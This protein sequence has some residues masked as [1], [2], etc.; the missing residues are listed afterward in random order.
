MGAGFLRESKIINIINNNQK[1]NSLVSKR[2]ADFL[3]L[4]SVKTEYLWVLDCWWD[5]VIMAATNNY[6]Y[7]LL[8]ASKMLHIV[9]CYILF[10]LLIYLLI[11]FSS[12]WLVVSIWHLQIACPIV[13]NPRILSLLSQNTKKNKSNASPQV[14]PT[15]REQV[16]VDYCFFSSHCP[17]YLF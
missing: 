8:P 2:F 16:D 17:F 13:Q 9:I 11:L 6:K 15:A 10:S 14:S 5:L 12:H 4:I 3:H 7:S 1:Q